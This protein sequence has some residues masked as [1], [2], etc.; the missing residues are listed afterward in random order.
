MRI[1]HTSDGI[2]S[3]FEEAPRAERGIT[4]GGSADYYGACSLET[5]CDA[6]GLTYTHDDAYGWLDYLDQFVSINFWRGDGSVQPWIYY[7][8]YDNWQDTYGADAVM[9]FYHSGHGGMRSDGVFEVPVGANWGGLGC[10]VFSNQMRLGNEQ[11]RYIFWSTCESLRVLGGH[12]PIRTWSPANLGFRMLFGFETVSWDDPDYGKAF[13]EEW[14]KGKSFSTAWLDASWYHVATDQS[15]SV[16]AVGATQA[17]AQNRLYNERSFSFSGVSKNWWSWRWY[18]AARGA[19]AAREPNRALPRDLVVA[20]L[21]PVEVSDRA[22]REAVDRLGLEVPLPEEVAATPEGIFSVGDGDAQ[23][24]FGGDGSF[25]ARMAQPN[26]ENRD[27]LP[28]RQATSAAEEAIGRHGLDEQGELTFDRV[29]RA[30]T[31]SASADGSETVEPSVTET[32]VQ[33]KQ[34]IN[35]LPV[36]TPDAGTVSITFDNDGTV[37]GVRSSVRPVERLDDRPLNTTTSPPEPGNPAEEQIARARATDAAGYEQLLAQE[38]GRRV[39]SSWAVRGEMPL[40]FTEVPG[41]T[42]VGYDIRG[43]SASLVARKAIEADFGGVLRKRYWV[44]APLLQ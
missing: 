27:Q 31:A 40:S 20:R 25:E 41:S 12:S 11:V 26:V 7:E 8:D 42:E 21:Q 14:K 44:T 32:T 10:R 19:G 16:V 15:P 35:G 33:Y 4:I 3:P 34:V 43:N 6:G 2:E 37:T 22:V 13:W 38:W 39:A 28:L 17:E 30:M 23:I 24:A 9:A 1:L 5:F 18:N 29:R 36:V